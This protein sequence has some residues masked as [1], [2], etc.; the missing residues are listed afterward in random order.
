MRHFWNIERLTSEGEFGQ[1]EET[2]KWE[3]N[4]CEYTCKCCVTHWENIKE[5]SA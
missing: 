2:H 3:K 5:N 1:C 4:Y